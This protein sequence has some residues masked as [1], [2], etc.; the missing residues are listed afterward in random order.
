MN[1]TKGHKTGW[2]ENYYV[3]LLPIR[4]EDY[5]RSNRCTEVEINR[6]LKA[7][8]KEVERIKRNANPGA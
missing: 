1:F 8:K 3:E 2:S 4:R 5:A 6:W 7:A